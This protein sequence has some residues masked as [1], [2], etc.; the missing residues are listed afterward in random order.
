MS[1]L[2]DQVRTGNV[3]AVEA[4]NGFP[5]ES[6]PPQ[7]DVT[8][9]YI[10]GTEESVHSNEADYQEALKLCAARREAM[11]LAKF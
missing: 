10:D 9:I 2:L 6:C 3:Q 8:L 1:K 4:R 7:G 5:L 11:E